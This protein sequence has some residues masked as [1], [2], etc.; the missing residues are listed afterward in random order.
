[1]PWPMVHFAVAQRLFEPGP[2]PA[3]LL[4]SIS[5]DAIHA[6]EHVTRKE[7]GVTHLVHEGRFP[8]IQTLQHAC[9][10]YLDQHRDPDWKAFVWGYFAHIYTD[11]RWTETLYA[12]FE[13][14]YAGDPDKI[15]DTYNREVSQLEFDLLK[16]EPWAQDALI[17]LRQARAFAV[18][19]LLTPDEVNRYRDMKLAWL[20]EE[21]HEPK[22]ETMYFQETKARRFIEKTAEEITEWVAWGFPRERSVT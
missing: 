2:S 9:V 8:S 4:G 17:Q 16:R 22:I 18:E 5:P 15:R 19:P 21:R 3:F 13:R 6:R 14:E 1:M 12:D 11:I 20:E 7:K 10:S